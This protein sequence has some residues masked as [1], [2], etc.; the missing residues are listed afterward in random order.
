M[1][2]FLRYFLLLTVL[3]AIQPAVAQTE[4][5]KE[6]ILH[7]KLGS[8]AI[9]APRSA[10]LFVATLDLRPQYTL[11]KNRLRAGLASGAFYTNRRLH[12]LYGPT[13]SVKLSEFKGGYFGSVGNVHLNFDH[14][15]TSDHRRLLGGGIN[16]DLLNKLVI[17]F[18]GLRDYRNNNWWWTSALAFRLSKVK[19]PVETFPN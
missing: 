2:I 15:W 11:V 5:P 8:G 10:E 19:K 13:V 17:G 1:Q 3:I 16:L 4:F 7:A 18:S 12:A 14:L 9:T 6:F